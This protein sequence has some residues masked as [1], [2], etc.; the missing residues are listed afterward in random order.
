MRPLLSP[1]LSEPGQDTL[2]AILAIADR[3]PTQT[4]R[5]IKLQSFAASSERMAG[6]MA[7]MSRLTSPLQSEYEAAKRDFETIANHLRL[8]A[9]ALPAVA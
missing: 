5:V 3:Q 7:A 9:S 2:S 8:E 6:Y 4:E 1:A